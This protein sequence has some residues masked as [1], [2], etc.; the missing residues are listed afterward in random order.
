VADDTPYDLGQSLD[1]AA[2]L[3]CG[4]L[5]GSWDSSYQASRVAKILYR[6]AEF[7]GFAFGVSAADG[8]TLE[9]VTAFVRAPGADGGLPS[10]SLMHVRRSALRLLFRSLRESGVAVGD[11]TLDLVLPPRSPLA[12]RP[13][14]DDEIVLCRGHALWSLSDLRRASAWA[15]AEATCRSVEIAQIRISDLDLDAGRVWIHGGRTTSPRRGHLTE[16][17]A[18]QLRRRIEMLPADPSTRVVYGG[19]GD[20]ATGQVSAS[21]AIADVL[22]RAGLAAEPDV[23]PA[24]IAAWAGCRVLAETGRIDE[25]ARRLG[26]ASLDRTARFIAFDWQVEN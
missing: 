7:S 20:E 1:A 25:V 4:L 22:T 24:S 21:V 8:V 18:G 23:R 6:F 9:V 3:A 15:L 26:M 16:W 10:L 14:A 13:L 19:S 2:T 17:G 5:A 11:P 12:T